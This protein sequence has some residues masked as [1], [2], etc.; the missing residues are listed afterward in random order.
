VEVQTGDTFGAG[1]DAKI[2]INVFGELGS[3]GE[4]RAG[5]VSS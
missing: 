3:T 1:S 5:W 4:L 2:L